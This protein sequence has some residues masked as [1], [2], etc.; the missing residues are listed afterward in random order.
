GVW[1]RNLESGYSTARLNAQNDVNARGANFRWDDNGS[2]AVSAVASS[3]ETENVNRRERLAVQVDY[4]FGR[5]D[6]ASE[7]QYQ[8]REQLTVGPGK[9]GGVPAIAD[10]YL[11]AARFGVDVH[12]RHNIYAIAQ[13]SFDE[14]AAYRENDRASIGIRSSIS[15]RLS[16]GTQ[17][18]DGDR[19]FGVLGE[20]NLY[21]TRFSVAGAFSAGDEPR[22]QIGSA[23]QVSSDRLIYTNYSLREDRFE[24]RRG[25]VSLG[26]RAAVGSRVNLFSEGQFTATDGAVSLSHAYGI[27]YAPTTEIGLGMSVQLSDLP[28]STTAV[29]DRDALSV[30][31][32]IESP[33]ISGHSRVEYRRD[34]YPTPQRQFVLID[35]AEWR[36]NQSSTVIGK[37]NHSVTTDNIQGVSP[38]RFTE[39]ALGYSYR[40]V[41]HNKMNLLSKYVYLYDLP[42][43]GQSLERPAQRA[44]VLSAET[45]YKL[46]GNCPWSAGTKFATRRGAVQ[47]Q[48]GSSV[49]LKSDRNLAIVQAR[50]F[51]DRLGVDTIAEYRILWSSNDN[52]RRNGFL[53]GVFREMQKY[54]TVGGGYN[55]SGFSDD[56]LR[57]DESEHGWFISATGKL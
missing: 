19:G 47:A 16:L 28:E 30:W 55:W 33:S 57:V 9:T 53:A 26:Q 50:Y 45:T 48:R 43:L 44:S 24:Q 49:W 54:L 8:S 11:A 34:A 32:S 15:D 10:A 12:P 21:F 35:R 40:P 3:V 39:G 14:S 27:D 51:W 42:S 2:F 38:G 20:I 7:V 46:C 31:A 1:W 37:L 36:V 25:I 17:V 56:L 4:E 13:T 41:R 22:A 23:W 52:Q 29:N 5:F 18:G 6:V